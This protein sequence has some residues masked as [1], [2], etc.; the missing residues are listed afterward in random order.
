MTDLLHL[1]AKNEYKIHSFLPLLDLEMFQQR[2]A[3][4]REP[5]IVNFK[6]H[7]QAGGDEEIHSSD[8]QNV[9]RLFRGID[10]PDPHFLS[11]HAGIAGILNTS[12]AGVFFDRL[13][14]EF[15]YRDGVPVI[16]SWEHLMYLKKLE[17]VRES[18]GDMRAFE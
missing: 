9:D 2:Q 6:A 16:C 15:A 1:Q 18:L 7:S 5:M 13:L 17:L 8:S 14:E 4:A 3:R 12:G 11:I 10:L